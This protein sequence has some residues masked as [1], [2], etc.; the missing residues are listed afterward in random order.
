MKAGIVIFPGI[1]RERDMA[2]ALKQSSGHEPR[3]IWH[4]ET[5]L[6]DLDLIV[7]P[8]GFSFGD[9]L[10]CGAMAARS[11]VMRAVHD[12]AV[13]GGYILGVCNGFQILTEAGLLPGALLRN[14]AL[15][16]LAMDCHLRVERADTVFTSRYQKGS[17]FR[18]VMAHGEGNYFADDATLDRLEYEG[19]VAFRY[20]DPSGEITPEANFNGSAR[21]IAGIV[22]PNR[23]VLGLMPHA[24]D[25]VDPLMGGA[26]GKPLFDSIAA[27]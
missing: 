17:T 8:G 25:L 9:Y 27:G 24:E 18:A 10:R 1:N 2:I 26:G 20:C 16:F 21:S 13:R 11:P 3:M 15:R 19:L 12:H 22:S 14:A 5:E 7:I 6:G 4:K 23:R